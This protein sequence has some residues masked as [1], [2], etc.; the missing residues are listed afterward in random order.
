[1]GERSK[2]TKI[3]HKG[4]WGRE[5]AFEKEMEGENLTRTRREG[6]RERCK[7]WSRAEDGNDEV[8]GGRAKVECERSVV[9]NKE[10]GECRRSGNDLD[11]GL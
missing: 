1:M 10:E 3:E 8:V 5:R 2:G 7:G 4:V 9:R 6:Q 11:F